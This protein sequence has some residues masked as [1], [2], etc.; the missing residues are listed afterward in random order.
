MMLYGVQ[1]IIKASK[2]AL[3][4]WAA[5]F[6]FTKDIRFLLVIWVRVRMAKR[7]AIVA[8]LKDSGTEE[9]FVAVQVADLSIVVVDSVPSRNPWLDFAWMVDI[10]CVLRELKRWW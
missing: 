3:S 4:V 9:D 1:V 10:D 5:F 2:M 8:S 6:S 7:F